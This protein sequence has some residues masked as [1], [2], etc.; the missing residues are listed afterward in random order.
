MILRTHHLRGEVTVESVLYV[1]IVFLIVLIGFHLAALLHAGHVGSVA[2]SRGAAQVASSM[3]SH[4]N[5]MRAID[6]INRVTQEMGGTVVSS[7]RIVESLTHFAVTVSLGS[8]R[9][10]PFLPTHVSRTATSA[11]ETFLDEQER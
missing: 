2:A 8:P 5:A 6:E 10:V 4:G 9:I 7:P 11:K 3:A 1:P